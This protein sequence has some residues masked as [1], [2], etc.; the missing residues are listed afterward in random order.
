VHNSIEEEAIKCSEDVAPAEHVVVV[1]AA[2]GVGA[3]VLLLDAVALL[4]G[5]VVAAF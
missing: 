2:A 5:V 3:A 1:D 4:L